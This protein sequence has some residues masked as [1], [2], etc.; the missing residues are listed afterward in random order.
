[1]TVIMTNMTVIMTVT[2]VGKR[3]AVTQIAGNYSIELS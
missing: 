1:M 2:V 3:A